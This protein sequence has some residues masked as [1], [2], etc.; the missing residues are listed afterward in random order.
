[1]SQWTNA[2]KA[3]LEDYLA[4]MRQPVAASG[5]DPSEVAED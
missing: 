1:M 2:A 3:K 5:A 4:R